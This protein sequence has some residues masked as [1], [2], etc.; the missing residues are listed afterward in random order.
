M[1]PAGALH[2][3]V[4]LHRALQQVVEHRPQF[5][6]FAA[7]FFHQTLAGKGEG[8]CFRS[9]L[10]QVAG[11]HQSLGEGREAL[12][13]LVPVGAQQLDCGGVPCRFSGLLRGLR[14]SSAICLLAR[15]N[16][17]GG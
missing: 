3:Q 12:E 14:P 8:N 1:R 13:E 5:G 11:S 4:E 15:R 7:H 9:L 16:S 10:V 17:R 6:F 2:N